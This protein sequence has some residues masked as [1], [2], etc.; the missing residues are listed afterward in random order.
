MK[1]INKTSLHRSSDK[2]YSIQSSLAPSDEGLQSCEG[3]TENEIQIQELRNER[4]YFPL[5]SDSIVKKT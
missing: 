1:G 4:I 2:P 3:R 5:Y